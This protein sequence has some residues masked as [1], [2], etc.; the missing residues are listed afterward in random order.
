MGKGEEHERKVDCTHLKA[1]KSSS[2]S[3]QASNYIDN[4]GW[5]DFVECVGDDNFFCQFYELLFSVNLP[6]EL[7]MLLVSFFLPLM[8]CAFIKTNHT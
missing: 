2:V 3:K 7:W 8:V 4:C 6:G 5:I 1:W